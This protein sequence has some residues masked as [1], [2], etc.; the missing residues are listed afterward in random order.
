MGPAVTGPPDPVTAPPLAEVGAS[1]QLMGL[2]RRPAEAPP[3][4]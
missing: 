1:A 2:A 3:D 4:H